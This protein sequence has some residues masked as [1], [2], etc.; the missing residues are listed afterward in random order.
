MFQVKLIRVD[1]VPMVKIY[2][3]LENSGALCTINDTIIV[4]HEL[5]Q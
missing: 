3:R 5:N 1:K 2:I 4:E